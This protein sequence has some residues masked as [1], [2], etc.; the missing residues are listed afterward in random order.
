MHEIN[1]H[2][3]PD[4]TVVVPDLFGR[5]DRRQGQ[6]HV[7]GYHPGPQEPHYIDMLHM[8]FIGV[9]IQTSW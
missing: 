2:S 9:D 3:K 1:Q 6:R 5:R 8:K 7:H 4:F